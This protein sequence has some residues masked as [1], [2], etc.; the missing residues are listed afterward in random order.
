MR[1]IKCRCYQS[2]QELRAAFAALRRLYFGR[3]ETRK[4]TNGAMF[5]FF[6]IVDATAEADRAALA[7]DKQLGATWG[8]YHITDVERIYA[9]SE[10]LT[11]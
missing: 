1:E 4:A 3:V 7:V 6:L 8:D 11:L 5:P 10:S 2:E 9:V